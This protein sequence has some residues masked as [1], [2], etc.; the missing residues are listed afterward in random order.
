MFT[1]PRR[2][3]WLPSSRP[4]AWCRTA[5]SWGSGHRAWSM[6]GTSAERPPH[7][8]H[9]GTGSPPRSLPRCA[10][11]TCIYVTG[12]H[13]LYVRDR[14]DKELTCYG[15]SHQLPGLA[16]CAE[17]LRW[18]DS[19]QW[20][21]RH[22]FARDVPMMQGLQHAQT[23]GPGRL[24]L[25]GIIGWRLREAFIPQSSISNKKSTVTPA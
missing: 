7:E 17:L 11:A 4:G 21:I 3:R 22:A 20:L 14:I 12:A 9:C 24:L 25:D 15:E 16:N 19:C 18:G 5:H 2:A 23:K 6:H 8:P 13:F 10:K 1:H